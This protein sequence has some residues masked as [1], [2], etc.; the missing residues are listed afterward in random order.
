M[1][2]TKQFLDDYD[3]HREPGERPGQLTSRRFSGDAPAGTR[4]AE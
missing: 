4:M 1:V 2:N 3:V